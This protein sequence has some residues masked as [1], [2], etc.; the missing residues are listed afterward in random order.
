VACPAI[1]L[2]RREARRS[3]TLA[4]L[5]KIGIETQ[6]FRR[7]GRFD[8]DPRRDLI[9]LQDSTTIMEIQ[10]LEISAFPAI[11]QFRNIPKTVLRDSDIRRWHVGWAEVCRFEISCAW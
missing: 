7:R 5:A 9:R 11:S 6:Q 1:K 4:E 10:G 3:T 8:F 2:D